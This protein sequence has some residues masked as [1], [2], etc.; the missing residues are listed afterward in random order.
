VARLGTDPSANKST[1]VRCSFRS[2]LSADLDWHGAEAEYRRALVLAPND[3][4]AKLLLGYQLAVFGD[5]E[6]AIE[7]TRQALATDPL[8]ATSYRWLAAYLSGLSRLD[9]AKRAIRR[10]IELQPRTAL[11]YR[12]LAIIEIQRGNP[13]AALAAAQQEL[14]GVYHDFAVALAR[15]IGDDRRAAD[16]A[17]STLTQNH[18][19]GFPYLVAD[20]YTLRK[21]AK[22]TFEWL[23]R[24]W[25]IR[26]PGIALLLFDP[27]MLRYKD[28]PRFA[29]FCRKVG[30]PVPGETSARNS[31]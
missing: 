31:N 19:T 15:Q 9:E 14:P 18:G 25:S 17:L 21:D 24:A 6:P 23:D 8:R 1:T 10:A 26:D 5:L 29:A 30:L 20:V 2:F 22:A 7:L 11:Q 12:R 4:E 27:F 3:G 16:A 13:H 28:D